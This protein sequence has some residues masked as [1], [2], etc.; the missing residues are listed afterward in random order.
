MATDNGVMFCL[1]LKERYEFED[2]FTL[3]GLT[4][5]TAELTWDLLMQLVSLDTENHYI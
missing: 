3:G 1:R 4:E 5:Q 2:I